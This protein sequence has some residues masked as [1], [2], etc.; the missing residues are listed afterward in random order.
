MTMKYWITG[1]LLLFIDGITKFSAQYFLSENSYNI[2][3][4]FFDLTL[5][6]NEGIAFS[7]PVPKFLQILLTLAFFVY[8]F[9][10]ASHNFSLLSRGEKWGSVILVSGAIGNFLERVFFGHVTD[11]LSVH[12]FSDF[13]FPIFNG[14]DIFIFIGVLLWIISAFWNTKQEETEIKQTQ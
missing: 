1:I 4:N 6:F 12:Y 9:M 8:F 10:W 5:A 14:A 11:F 13:Y 7:I 3:Q 2:I